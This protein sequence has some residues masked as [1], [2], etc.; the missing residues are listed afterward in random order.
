[1]T[2]EDY[3]NQVEEMI[4]LGINKGGVDYTII[5]GNCW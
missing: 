3:I 2:E 1:M 5:I 4:E